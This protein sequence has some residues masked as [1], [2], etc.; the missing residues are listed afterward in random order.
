MRR[1]FQLPEADREFLDS[2]K[3]WEAVID[4]GNRWVIV[5]GFDVPAGY[6]H[7]SVSVGLILPASYPDVQIDMAYFLPD[8]A[9]ADGKV[10]NKL[11]PQS[12]D[13]KMW[14]RWSRH[15]PNPALDWRPGIDNIQTH[16]VYVRSWLEEEFKKR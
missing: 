9:R 7:T 2:V 1:D 16:L 3:E 6:N 14:Q 11:S 4:G 12:L 13:G 15:R 5:G 10:I 8:L